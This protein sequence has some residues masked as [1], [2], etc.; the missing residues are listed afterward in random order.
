MK[1]IRELVR[2]GETAGTYGVE[3]EVEGHA[4]PNRFPHTW[5]VEEDGSLKAQ[6]AH[7][8]VMGKPADL[9][10]VR[11]ALDLM[12]QAFDECKSEVDESI[13]A[14]VHVHM[15]V[16]EWNMKELMTFVMVYYILEDVLMEW[17]GP[18]REGNLF[19]LR[20]RDAEYVL[21]RLIKMLRTRDIRLVNDE[22]IRYSSLNFCSLFRYGSIEFRG[23]RSTGDLDTIYNWV[24]IIDDMATSSKKFSDP[25][26]VLASMSGDGG[27]A[28]F[29][30]MLPNT[31][32]L[33][34]KDTIEDRVRE[35]ARR[36]Q[37]VAYSTDWDS[38]ADRGINPFVQKGF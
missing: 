11:A 1:K 20:T 6:E 32:H 37:I 21:F 13:R 35:A 2:V 16:Q 38:L 4:L 23:M 28:F 34:V 31:H 29:E 25:V 22:I 33:F 8:Y 30:A 5:R 19:C 36:V 26:D 3:I 10:G 27:L 15:N 12:Q 17:C 18:N 24:R 14:G 9:A 7:E